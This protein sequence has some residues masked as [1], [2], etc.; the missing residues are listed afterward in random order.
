M[1]SAGNRPR[2][3]SSYNPHM[4]KTTWVIWL[5]LHVSESGLVPT[6]RVWGEPSMHLE[7]HLLMVVGCCYQVQ[8]CSG[9]W[10][11]AQVQLTTPDG[12]PLWKRVSYTWTLRTVIW[13]LVHVT[14]KKFWWR[15]HTKVH[16]E[17]EENINWFAF[18]CVF[19]VRWRTTSWQ[20]QPGL[21]ISWTQKNP[22][23]QKRN[24]R[25]YPL[26]KSNTCEVKD[27]SLRNA[28]LILPV[29]QFIQSIFWWLGW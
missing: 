5:T 20:T 28:R 18:F 4:C 15:Y 12:L 27:R 25:L 24:L 22:G 29:G 16:T 19:H 1:R 11:L 7:R 10:P 2:N 23:L 26:P 17:N 3:L 21:D 9:G 13:F 8:D 6:A 14:N